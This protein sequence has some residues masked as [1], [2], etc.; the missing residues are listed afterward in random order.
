M[1]D[2]DTTVL[3]LAQR[4]CEVARQDA[5]FG[6]VQALVAFIKEIYRGTVETS[7]AENG[8]AAEALLRRALSV[9]ELDGRQ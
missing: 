8:L 9:L 3:N 4:F 7:A 5:H 2:S 1:K 6:A